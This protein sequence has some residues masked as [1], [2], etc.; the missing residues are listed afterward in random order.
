MA[1]EIEETFEVDRPPGE[2]WRFLADPGRV[3]ECLPQ[4]E[5][6][7]EIDDRTFRGRMGLE[8]GPASMSFEG[9]IRFDR[10]DEEEREVEMSGTASSG[11]GRGGVEMRMRSHL[12][13]LEDGGT[14]VR[15]RQHLELT[16]NLA[17]FGRGALMEGLA[18]MMFGRFARCVEKELAGG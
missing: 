13:P 5:L 15:V 8:L 2:V 10:L 16:G 4:G 12:D 14:R 3:V 17:S 9:R 6:V 18:E 1:I 11:S 7:E